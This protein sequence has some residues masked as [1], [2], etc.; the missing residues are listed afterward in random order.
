MLQ[1]LSTDAVLSEV[2]TFHP[3]LRNA[4]ESILAQT[5]ES[6][7]QTH[8]VAEKERENELSLT[9]ETITYETLEMFI[10]RYAPLQ[11]I[12]DRTKKTR[13]IRLSRKILSSCNMILTASSLMS[14][15]LFE[16]NSKPKNANEEVVELLANALVLDKRWLL[17]H[18]S[19]TVRHD[20]ILIQAIDKHGWVDNDS[21]FLII[22]D[23]AVTK[24]GWPFDAVQIQKPVVEL[25]QLEKDHFRAACDRAAKFLNEEQELMTEMRGFNQHTVIRAFGLV[26]NL[27]VSS[28]WYAD[29]SAAPTTDLNDVAPTE[30]NRAQLPSKKDMT[31]RAKTVLCHGTL[32]FD[33][34][35]TVA[36]LDSTNHFT[37]VD[38]NNKCNL[39]LVELLRAL[40]RESSGSKAS[41]KICALASAEAKIRHEETAS[42]IKDKL[43]AESKDMTNETEKKLVG[44]RNVLDHLELVKRNLNK[45]VRL[46]KNVIRVMLG[47]EPQK[48]K[49][50]EEDLFPSEK[51][52]APLIASQSKEN[53]SKWL[54]TTA[55]VTI[56]K[57]RKRLLTNFSSRDGMKNNAKLLHLTEIETL[58]L[59]ALCK[60][61]VPIWSKDWKKSFAASTASLSPSDVASWHSLG[62]FVMKVANMHYKKSSERLEVV[63]NDFKKVQRSEQISSTDVSNSK[64]LASSNLR[65]AQHLYD[66]KK[67]V[68]RQATDY[69]ANSDH[70]AK[71]SI[72]L[73]AKI[74]TDMA[75]VSVVPGLDPKMFVWLESEIQRWATSLDLLADNGQPLA[76]TAIDFLEDL[77][78]NE[79]ETIKVFSS[80]DKLSSRAVMEQTAT[81]TRLRSIFSQYSGHGSRLREKIVDAVNDIKMSGVAWEVQPVGW[82]EYKDVVLLHRLARNGF[83]DTLLGSKEHFGEQGAV[84]IRRV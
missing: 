48:G 12:I 64:A 43:T 80:F 44:Y 51:H 28:Q 23:K 27:I 36:N 46:Y 73:L 20:A 19:W 83:T 39:L 35:K 6:R 58:I 82:E 65:K 34:R 40:L 55:D 13:R 50:L 14:Q 29:P 54:K 37:Q 21:S 77:P 57:A 18:P 61:G 53:D 3:E 84:S 4:V 31:K 33:S 1:F 15:V 45:S 49:N 30:F 42:S 2:L 71:K 47:E 72:L 76:F 59:S 66:E 11:L 38:Q 75:S 78:L 41:H 10:Y 56:D 62:H 74:Q 60:L 81:M 63:T 32:V 7:Q 22:T 8:A 67:E 68:F 25:S 16:Q 70:L 9:A 5:R 26:K 24:W 69:Q 52:V 79:R 17:P